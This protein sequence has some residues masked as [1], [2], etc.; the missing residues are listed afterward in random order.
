MQ[1]GA[2]YPVN[3]LTSEYQLPLQGVIF[4][5][6]VILNPENSRAKVCRG[7]LRDEPA[8]GCQK[9]IKRYDLYY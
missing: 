4:P 9:Q 2:E 3:A 8:N 1:G 6:G 5:F 7:K